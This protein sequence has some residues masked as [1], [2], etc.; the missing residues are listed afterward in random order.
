M[1]E[2]KCPACGATKSTPDVARKLLTSAQTVL[3]GETDPARAHVYVPAGELQTV[4][5]QLL[6]L[7]PAEPVPKPDHELAT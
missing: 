2:P 4:C 7:T 5:E 6:A 3:D 1:H